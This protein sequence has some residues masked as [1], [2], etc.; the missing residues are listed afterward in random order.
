MKNNKLLKIAILLVFVLSVS[1]YAAIVSDNDGSAFITKA[2]FEAMKDSFNSQIDGYNKSI[3]GKIDG[4]IASYLSGI[5]LSTS[6]KLK[7]CTSKVVYPLQFQMQNKLL[8]W[9]NWD[10][11]DGAGNYQYADPY[12]APNWKVYLLGYRYKYLFSV[13][14]TMTTPKAINKFY[15]GTWDAGKSKFI[16]SNSM[17]NVEG[18]YA[19]TGNFYQLTDHEHEGNVYVHFVFFTDQNYKVA[20][21]Y[22][23]TGYFTRTPKTSLTDHLTFYAQTTT[24]H[25]TLDC[26]WDWS[27]SNG[28]SKQFTITSSNSKNVDKF[29]DKWKGHQYSWTETA[30][31]G[32]YKV[33]ETLS[34]DTG[35]IDFIMNQTD[36]NQTN[37]GKRI[38]IP[39]AYSNKIY[40]TNRNNMKKDINP[41]VVAAYKN[42]E[43]GSHKWYM[44]SFIT[45]GWTLEPQF[46]GS[47]HSIYQRSLLQ[48]SDMIYEVKTPNSSVVKYQQM[49]QGILLTEMP[50]T[51]DNEYQYATLKIKISS[52]NSAEKKYIVLSKSPITEVDHTNITSS[53]TGYIKIGDSQT[54]MTNNKM[55]L[56]EN[57]NTIY[58]SGVEKS[59]LI[60]YKILWSKSDSTYCNV[61]EE[62]EFII[63]KS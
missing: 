13:Q 50:T 4:A 30:G 36:S 11:K 42:G 46:S 40:L 55:E 58:V 33:T 32:D 21:D 38:E 54:T 24:P 59:D 8:N 1:L 17:K 16:I 29:L 41:S 20:R 10:K 63:T 6:E 3:D 2:E 51:G 7:N 61:T 34:F 12:W 49:D 31:I 37:S 53:S 39:V 23:G 56:A 22:A 60:Y 28:T 5:Q 15:N 9:T 45:P 52:E 27:G 62:P 44:S 48:P 35:D 14:N 25:F 19:L 26:G 47:A 43:Y 18:Q 57:E